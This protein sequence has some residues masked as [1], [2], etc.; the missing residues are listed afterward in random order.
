MES[1]KA[2][3]KTVAGITKRLREREKHVKLGVRLSA[4]TEAE[5]EYRF[6]ICRDYCAFC[7]YEED[8]AYADRVLYDRR[9]YMRVLF[10]E[11]EE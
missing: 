5:S 8:L 10:P 4:V 7:R 6:L 9:D 1:R 3:L 2:A 11:N